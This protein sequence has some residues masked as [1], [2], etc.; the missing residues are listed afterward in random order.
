[1]Y[2][3][4]PTLT[5]KAGKSSTRTCPGYSDVLVS[6][7]EGKLKIIQNQPFDQLETCVLIKSLKVG[8]VEAGL[9]PSEEYKTKSWQWKIHQEIYNHIIF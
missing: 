4:Y 8:K 1:M 7:Q 2:I 5:G 6:S 3:T 9:M